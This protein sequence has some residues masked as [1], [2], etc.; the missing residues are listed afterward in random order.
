MKLFTFFGTWVG[1]IILVVGF[2]LILTLLKRIFR[3]YWPKWLQVVDFLPPLLL[4]LTHILSLHSFGLTVAPFLIL[5]WCLIGIA[6]ALMYAYRDG[7]L[8]YAKFF[9]TIWKITDIYMIIWY[10]IILILLLF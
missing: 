9:K 6:S 1:S 10:L 5:A 4:L 8:I 3:K 2:V 7:E